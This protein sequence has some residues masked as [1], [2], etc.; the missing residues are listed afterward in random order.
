MNA[1]SARRRHEELVEQGWTR[2]FDAEEPRLSEM[3]QYYVSLGFEVRVEPGMLGED[4]ACS[5]CFS[6]EG[7]QD[8]YS[9]LYTRGE[10]RATSDELF[11]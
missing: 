5:S 4:E 11:D 6:A 9:T 8:R 1:E 10:P 2:R 7:F 3:R